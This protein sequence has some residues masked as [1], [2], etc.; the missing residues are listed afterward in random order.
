METTCQKVIIISKGK[1]VATDTMA[2]LNSRLRGSELLAVEVGPRSG[3]LNRDSV[4]DR[5]ASVPG[6][7][8]VEFKDAIESRLVFH[9]ESQQGASI[10]AEV[11]RTVVNAD[12][13]LMELHGAGLSLEEIFL[14]LTASDKGAK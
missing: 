2:N 9:V 11:A 13:N 10:R 8:R 14:Q 4:R 3:S 1:L 5:L 6:V 12:W 7:S